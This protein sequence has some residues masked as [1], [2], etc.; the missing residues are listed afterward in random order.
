MRRRVAWLRLTVLA[1][2][3][4]LI[5]PAREV[6]SPGGGDCDG[7]RL[8]RRACADRAY[9]GPLTAN[10]SGPEVEARWP[11][12][13]HG[14]RRA[15]F[16]SSLPF[17]ISLALAPRAFPPHCSEPR[18]LGPRPARRAVVV[19][20][21]PKARGG[22]VGAPRLKIMEAAVAAISPAF[23]I[24]APRIRAEQDPAGL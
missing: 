19:V 4:E 9:G 23:L 17:G 2:V 21:L 11:E 20:Q 22:H 14:T 3:L 18:L 16:A 12:P 6:A 8:S 7:A 24:L 13:V 1:A 5:A 15:Q 10:S